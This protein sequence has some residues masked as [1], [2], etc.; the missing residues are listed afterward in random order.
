MRQKEFHGS[1]II[2]PPYSLNNEKGSG[3][4]NYLVP[5][6]IF[7]DKLAGIITIVRMKRYKIHPRR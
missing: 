6:L 2:V 5:F 3:N 1:L 4:D 7:Y